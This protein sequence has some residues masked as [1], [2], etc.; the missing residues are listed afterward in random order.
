M[1]EV[2]VSQLPAL[3]IAT[4]L[5]AA[6]SAFLVNA[7]GA[8]AIS[9]VAAGVETVFAFALAVSVAQG[10]ALSYDVGGWGAPVGIELSVD[11]L[12][13]VMIALA[14]V[15]GTAVTVYAAQYCGRDE[16]Y[17]HFWPLWL[18]LWGSLV[19]LFSSN[20][21]F[22]LYV[23]L[24]LVS[25][26]AVALVALAASRPALTAAMRYMLAAIAGSLLYLFGV[27]L[28]YGGAGV[29]DLGELSRMALESP[30]ARVGL[31][32]AV[33]G[34]IVKTALVP[35]HFWL[36]P[37][38]ANSISPVS[39]V[40]SALV[41][42]GSFFI[43]LRLMTLLE[44]GQAVPGLPVL[45]GV[46]GAA[47]IVWGS[48]QA[49]VQSRLKMLVAYSTVAQI[50]Y[51]FIAFPL[52][53]AATVPAD[54]AAA[55]S[56]TSFHALAHALAKGAMFLAAGT[57]LTGVGHDRIGELTGL[58]RRMPS[59]ALAFGLAGVSMLGLPPSGGFVSKWLYV[60]TA[61]KVGAWWWAIPVIGGGLLAA[62]YIFRAV[63]TFLKS[64]P[65][66][67]GDDAA[68]R[69]SAGAMSWIPLVLAMLSLAVGLF[70][71]PV[72]D[73][74]APAALAMVGG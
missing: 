59:Q 49:F 15:V 55:V 68:D 40:M 31:G 23:C 54:A 4:L 35:L 16:R 66:A 58:A 67:A 8:R 25:V 42:K 20:D 28:L 41:I 53:D 62:G 33:V 11:G 70:A 45:L 37:A 34:L 6:P 29:L 14:A 27:A 48:V 57:I 12:S 64:A 44:G 43:L 51:L 1:S 39:A 3:T 72:L 30:A 21:I 22:N 5:L 71:Q 47:A 61:I 69:T 17:R 9:L 19:A 50:G 73:L 2:F 46:L 38:H 26:S 63:A 24:E 18:F 10:G 7:R 65:S 13:A 60:V 32:L 52:V 74:L 56:A 36:P